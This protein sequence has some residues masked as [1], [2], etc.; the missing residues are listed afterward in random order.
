MLLGEKG[1]EVIS[2]TINARP[3][4]FAPPI[5]IARLL[6]S[7][8]RSRPIST[9]TAEQIHTADQLGLRRD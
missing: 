8:V 1:G 2:I 3:E 6:A 9:T 5:V 4:T 7:L